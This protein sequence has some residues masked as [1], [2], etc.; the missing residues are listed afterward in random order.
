MGLLVKGKASNV[1]RQDRQSG[2]GVWVTERFALKTQLNL[3]WPVAIDVR[4]GS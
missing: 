2:Y 1:L 3:S 4:P